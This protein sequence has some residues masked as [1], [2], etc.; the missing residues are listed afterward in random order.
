M[1]SVLTPHSET[2]HSEPP[3][4]APQA[5]R[6]RGAQFRRVDAVTPVRPPAELGGTDPLRSVVALEPA[7]PPEFATAFRGYNRVQVDAFVND[8]RQR[9]AAMRV[10]A[11][12]AETELRRLRPP[13]PM[14]AAPRG[15]VRVS[16]RLTV[17][18]ARGAL[19]LGTPRLPAVRAK[20]LSRGAAKG[21]TRGCR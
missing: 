14:L 18:P 2:L 6:T 5:E 11:R 10:R 16:S 7:V 9:L 20:G 4:G 15:A 19:G 1:T 3:S 12:R 21:L 8:L 13:H 17:L